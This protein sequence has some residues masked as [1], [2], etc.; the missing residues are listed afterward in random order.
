LLIESILTDSIYEPLVAGLTRVL[1]TDRL[2]AQI[3]IVT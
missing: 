2:W 3:R 1:Y